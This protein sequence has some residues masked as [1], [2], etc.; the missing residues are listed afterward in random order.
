MV[1]NEDDIILFSP[2]APE[3]LTPTAL[4]TVHHPYDNRIFLPT[5]PSPPSSLVSNSNI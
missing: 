3:A 2:K 1:E 4:A 5:W